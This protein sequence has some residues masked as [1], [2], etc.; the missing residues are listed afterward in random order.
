M[1]VQKKRNNSDRSCLLSIFSYNFAYR[2]SKFSEASNCVKD[3]R[4]PASPDSA[5]AALLCQCLLILLSLKLILALRRVRKATHV[6]LAHGSG[7]GGCVQANAK[8]TLLAMKSRL[9]L[10]TFA[11]L[12][13]VAVA[14]VSL[15]SEID[16]ACYNK[17]ADRCA[18]V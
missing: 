2:S 9:L 3:C 8:L 11:V 4:V 17:L 5:N 6:T 13:F 1:L 10:C 7:N 14:E 15:L 12:I 18:L 16:A